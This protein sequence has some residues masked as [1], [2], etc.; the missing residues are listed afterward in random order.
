MNGGSWFFVE[1]SVAV[2]ECSESEPYSVGVGS[3]LTDWDVLLDIVLGIWM[4]SLLWPVGRVWE[5][6]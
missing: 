6:G 1:L 3:G 5:F 4:K 2:L